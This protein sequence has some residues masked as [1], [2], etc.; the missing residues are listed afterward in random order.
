MYGVTDLAFFER[1]EHT[2][3]ADEGC[4]DVS[5]RGVGAL[6][7]VV[8]GLNNIENECEVWRTDI[9]GIRNPFKWRVVICRHTIVLTNS[10]SRSPGAHT[11]GIGASIQDYVPWSY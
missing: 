7:R 1:L 3:G 4:T 11:S 8:I 2:L 5:A 10:A 6:T 9:K